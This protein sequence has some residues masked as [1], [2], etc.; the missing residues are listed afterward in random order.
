MRKG[1]LNTLAL[2]LVILAVI[3]SVGCSTVGGPFNGLGGD[4]MTMLVIYRTDDKPLTKEQYDAVGIVAKKMGVQIG[5]QLSSSF[6]SAAMSGLAYGAAGTIGG[7]T[8]G[9]FYDG[10]L[11]PAAAGFTGAVYG[12]GG[13]VNGLVTASYAN[14]YA[15]AAATE[16]AMR[17]EERYSPRNAKN[18]ER[19]H[20]VAA[21]IRSRNNAG[22]PAPGLTERMPNW[23]G[24]VSGVPLSG[25][26]VEKK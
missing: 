2:L 3:A 23:H 18:F 1:L 25:T 12:L 15:V 11:V 16:V 5:W 24:P 26:P 4:E 14:V 13:A 8:Q 17:D 10:V 22:A 6:E 21:F 9:L 19:V 7:A 20:V